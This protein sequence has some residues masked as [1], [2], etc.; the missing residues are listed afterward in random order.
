MNRR[1]SLAAIG[2]G[3]MFAGI[4][5]AGRSTMG[6]KS[7]DTKVTGNP[8]AGTG[9]LSG[10]VTA[11]KEFK[12]ASVYATNKDNRTVFMVYTVD[13]HYRFVGLI[14]GN[15]DVTV[16][17][18][19]FSGGNA[20]SVTV[21]AGKNASADLTIQ[22]GNFHAAQGIRPGQLKNVKLLS[23]DELYPAGE[24]RALI[25][26]TC[27]HCHGPD[28][29]PGHE[30]DE[31]QWNAAIDLMSDTSATIPGRILPGTFTAQERQHLVEYL[32]KN[33]GPD[34]VSRGLETPQ[35]PVDEQAIGKSM[36]VEYHLPVLAGGSRRGLHDSHFDNQGNVWYVDRSGL[37]VGRLDPRTASFKDYAIA[38]RLAQPHGLT[39]DHEGHMWFTSNVALGEVDAATG[40]ITMYDFGTHETNKQSHGH[41][42][43]VD[44][45]DNV[46]FTASYSDE[47][48]KW[49]HETK[50]ITMYK[51]PTRY[52][53]PYALVLDK[54]DKMWMAEWSRCKV[55][56]FD[57]DNGQ[58]IEYSPLS[59]P[60]TMRRLS[61]DHKGTIW[62][63][64]DGNGIIGKLDPVTGKIAEFE[65]PVKYGWP[66]DIQPDKDDNIWISDSGQG[67]A[68][69]K[70]DPKTMKF[71]YFPSPQRT[72]MPKIEVSRDGAIWYTT[73]SADSDK[74]AVGV[75]Y[76]DISK[77]TTMAP[78]Y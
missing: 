59:R 43:V 12:S 49:D 27:M 39:M 64:L 68:L 5:V 50:K 22:E 11:P 33:Y 47:I 28:F 16:A 54:N 66:Y 77:L 31:S 62:Y 52:S 24:G 38:D 74:Q 21:E 72:D 60:C 18:N 44:S 23:Y 78:H 19:G 20:Q 30:W 58:F 51:V 26:R 63:A 71:T 35:I 29:I 2:I 9:S 10:V 46:W 7:P 8:I 42:P 67:G 45:K 48:G 57:P 34:G 13:G 6:E 17:K 14:P 69:V 76:P 4:L 53:F 37:Q 36:Y 3:L 41:T 73:R 55:V 40:E 1:S 25:E 15:Y 65:M 70:L 75:L 32:V 61:I 56:K